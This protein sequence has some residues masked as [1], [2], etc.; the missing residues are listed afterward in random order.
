MVSGFQDSEFKNHIKTCRVAKQSGHLIW[1][2]SSAGFL[3]A[4]EPAGRLV[5]GEAMKG[6]HRCV[7]ALRAWWPSG[8]GSHGTSSATVCTLEECHLRADAGGQ[9]GVQL[10]RAGLHFPG[11]GKGADRSVPEG[12]GWG[13]R[14]FSDTRPI[15]SAE[16]CDVLA[17]FQRTGCGPAFSKWTVAIC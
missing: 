13:L 12:Q 9:V 11:A 7:A 5:L 1:T 14:Y 2:R 17:P 3:V 15:P 8:P 6:T 4:V 16:T 10:V